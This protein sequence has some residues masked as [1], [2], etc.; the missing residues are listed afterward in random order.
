M[1]YAGEPRTRPW[2]RQATA[3]AAASKQQRTA[4]EPGAGQAGN[5]PP[6]QQH[7]RPEWRT[8]VGNS[9]GLVTWDWP[10]YPLNA[11]TR[12]PEPAL[13]RTCTPTS[14]GLWRAR[15]RSAVGCDRDPSSSV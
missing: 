4:R 13:H 14:T 3:F 15:W 10:G 7:S 8:M 9:L 5:G 6:R 12:P 1:H 2:L 11:L